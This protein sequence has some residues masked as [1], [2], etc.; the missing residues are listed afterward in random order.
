MKKFA[1]LFNLPWN[2]IFEC[3]VYL[4]F[5]ASY[6][7]FLSNLN[8]TKHERANHVTT[9]SKRQTRPRLFTMAT[10]ITIRESK[11]FTTMSVKH[12]LAVDAHHLYR[13]VWY[14]SVWHGGI[15]PLDVW[16]TSE[17]RN[18]QIHQTHLDQGLIAHWNK[19]EKINQVYLFWTSLEFFKYFLW[20][21]PNVLAHEIW[22]KQ[23][24]NESTVT[25]SSREWWT[26]PSTQDY[27]TYV[28]SQKR[29]GKFS[30]SLSGLG[31]RRISYNKH[32]HIWLW[33]PRNWHS[34]EH[35]GKLINTYS[36]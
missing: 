12:Y 9:M 2:A 1:Q 29:D 11:D 35:K 6:A 28:W 15:P 5:P 8:R 23:S 10:L 26:H 18:N 20:I 24:C 21:Q 13:S 30:S 17:N 36:F 27:D 16:W 22:C 31:W 34:T 7:Y 32:K 19:S 3:V 4:P 14:A 33:F 25:C